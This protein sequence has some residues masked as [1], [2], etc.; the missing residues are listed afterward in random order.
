MTQVQHVSLANGKWQELNLSEQ[1]GNIGSEI[2]RAIHSKNNIDKKSATLRAME[3]F[4]LSLADKRWYGRGSELA[5]AR[6]VSADY[7]I[8][9]N[10][11]NTTPES[12]ENY[13]MQFALSARLN[14]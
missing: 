14:R 13:F 5:R 6:E 4:D 3:L 8:G 1:L 7:L 12:L 2:G 9:D 11:Y 10:Q